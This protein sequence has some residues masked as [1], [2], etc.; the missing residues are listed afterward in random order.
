MY[1]EQKE[2]HIFFN[3]PTF[4]HNP[5]WGA[6]N[7]PPSQEVLFISSTLIFYALDKIGAARHGLR[8][9]HEIDSEWHIFT[10]MV[11]LNDA[12]ERL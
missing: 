11:L 4:L 3:S 1:T 9:L 7:Y 10:C 5:K 8:N 12:S 6:V 2:T